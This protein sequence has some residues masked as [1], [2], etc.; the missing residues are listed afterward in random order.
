[1]QDWF[2]DATVRVNYNA[3]H[4]N[5]ADHWGV[6]HSPGQTINPTGSQNPSFVTSI[7]TYPSG[8]DGA[9][10]TFY[11]NHVK[12]VFDGEDRAKTNS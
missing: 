4:H 2:V 1:M 3:W 5:V 6:N 7:T 10:L 12:E 9:N 11:D 8:W